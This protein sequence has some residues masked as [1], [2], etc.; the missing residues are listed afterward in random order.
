MHTRQAH[1]RL[2]VALCRLHEWGEAREALQRA[3]QLEPTDAA[4]R[5]ELDECERRRAEARSRERKAS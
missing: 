4:I 2:G 1:F 3:A 5:R